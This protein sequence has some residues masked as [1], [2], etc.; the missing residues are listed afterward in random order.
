MTNEEA[1]KLAKEF[2]DT[3][4]SKAFDL[5]WSSTFNLAEP[6]KYFD[7]TGARDSEDFL[8]LTRIG[9]YQA[10]DSFEPDRGSTFLTWARMRMTQMLIKE[11]RGISRA[12]RLGY[13][14]SLD[15]ST[16]GGEIKDSSTIEQMIYKQLVA[17]DSYQ[18]A[19]I[20]WSETLYWSIIYDIEENID[21]N[22][23]I[24]RVFWAKL[25]FPNMTRESISIMLNLSKPTISQH[26]EIIRNCITRATDKYAL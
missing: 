5:L 18:A 22:R 21:N 20:E 1:L 16:I 15:S 7:P 4:S 24:S 3:R 23:S 10:I 8:Q 13:K 11:L 12:S 6:Y 17:S 9:L 19:T 2:K 26:F 14:I 25:A